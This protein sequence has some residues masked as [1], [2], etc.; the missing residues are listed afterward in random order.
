MRWWRGSKTILSLVF[1]QLVYLF[2]R[3]ATECLGLLAY[4]RDFGF[5]RAAPV[6]DDDSAV[7]L[8]AFIVI[9]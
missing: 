1:I 7:G 2:S 6:A 9:D 8:E 5:E 3:F 4:V